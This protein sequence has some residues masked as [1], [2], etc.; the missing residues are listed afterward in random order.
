[1]RG[2]LVEALLDGPEVARQLL[3]PFGRG[4]TDE[5]RIDQVAQLRLD[6]VERH[7][8]GQVDAALEALLQAVPELEDIQGQA[9][10]AFGV[11]GPGT[12]LLLGEGR[13]GGAVARQAGFAVEDT[14]VQAG[15]ENV[16]H[17]RIDPSQVAIEQAQ[18]GEAGQLATEELRGFRQLL[19][20]QA[21]QGTAVLPV[22][23]CLG[24]EAAFLDGPARSIS[25][26]AGGLHQRRVDGH[27]EAGDL[28]LGA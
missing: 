18:F 22:G 26:R 17:Q 21:L 2:N 3:Q 9:G 13:E 4:F 24:R 27:G 12:S 16:F 7:R 6:V 14:A 25:I 5:A 10:Q 1:M 20:Q 8:L 19:Q 15:Q 23:F 11:L 28:L